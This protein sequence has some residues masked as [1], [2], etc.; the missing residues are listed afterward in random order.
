M[1]KYKAIVCILPKQGLLDPQGKAI[2]RILNEI[3]FPE[4]SH[5]RVGRFAEFTIFANNESSARSRINE[6]CER[7]LVN[8][9]MESF[10]IVNVASC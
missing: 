7:E 10:V 2:H 1:L 6:I 5:V 8:P 9:I 3:D 4:V